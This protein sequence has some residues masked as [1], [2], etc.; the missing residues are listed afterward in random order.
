[1]FNTRRATLTGCYSFVHQFSGLES[2]RESNKGIITI[3][4]PHSVCRGSTGGNE[5][6]R[7]RQIVTH[8]ATFTTDKLLLIFLRR[9]YLRFKFV[10]PLSL[11]MQI[12]SV[13]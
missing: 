11:G 9:C 12:H 10:Y 6:K 3:Y 7:S 4:P 1:M 2:H 5:N 13:V 8:V